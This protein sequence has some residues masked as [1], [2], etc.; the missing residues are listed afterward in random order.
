MIDRMIDFFLER[1][2]RLIS[3][4]RVLVEVGGFVLVIGAI[5]RVAT[6]FPGIT[7][8]LAKVSAPE[9]TLADLYPSLPTWWIPESIVGAIPALA[10]IA[11][12][13]WLAMT[14]RRLSRYLGMD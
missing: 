4:G 10:L 7:N 12:G 2:K 3:L 14:G 13:F 6:G 8:M 5:G 11:L 9:K 1:P